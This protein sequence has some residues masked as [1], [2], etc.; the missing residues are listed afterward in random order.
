M[1]LRRIALLVA[2]TALVAGA[3]PASAGPSSAAAR[4]RDC[5]TPVNPPN[6]YISS[7]RNMTC[8]AAARDL[9]RYEGSYSRRFKTPGGFS[10]RR[11]SGGALGGQWRCVRGRRAYRFEFGD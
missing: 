10:C 2:T 4:V 3:V 7:A 8:R 9:K 5:H 1:S 11:V 6:S